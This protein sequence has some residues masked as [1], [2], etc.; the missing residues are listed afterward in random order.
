MIYDALDQVLSNFE[1]M[2][3]VYVYA[4]ACVHIHTHT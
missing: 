2:S 1:Q 3:S 4:H